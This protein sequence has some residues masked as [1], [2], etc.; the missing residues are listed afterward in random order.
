LPNAKDTERTVTFL[1][2]AG[3]FALA[4]SDEQALA[5][6]IEVGA[7]AV[8]MTE[9][10][11]SAAG[12]Q[13][14]DR[15]LRR[16]PLAESVPLIVLSREA[17]DTRSGFLSE[18]S[19]NV[20][21]VERP[22]RARTLVSVVQATLRAR[23]DQYA[24]RDALVEREHQAAAIRDRDE[25]LQFA[26]EA[27]KLGWW[28]VEF[29]SGNMVCSNICRAHFGRRP[30]E[31]FTYASLHASIHRT[32]AERIQMAISRC[33]YEYADYDVEYRVLWPDGQIHW[34]MVRGKATYREDGTAQ[35]MV[36]VS[37]DITDRKEAEAALGAQAEQLRYS[38][39]R[40]DEFLATLA[41]ELR[42]PLAPI[43]TGLGILKRAPSGES[44]D[45]A[46]DMMD[47][48]LGHM[49][50]LIDDLMDLSRITRGKV[51]LKKERVTLRSVVD[52]TVE[53]TRPLID[54][55]AHK[56]S[57]NLPPEPVYFDVDPTRAGQIIGNL[58]NNAAKYTPDGGHIDIT[59]R[60][61]GPCVVIDVKDDGLGI[62]KEQLASVFDM[63]SQVDRTLERSQG[64]LGIGL[65][66]VRKLL[67]MHEG[68]IS[69]TSGGSGCGSTFTVRFPV[70][71]ELKNA[72]PS[73]A[74][75]SKEHEAMKRILVVDDN[76]DA[77]ECLSMLL[78][79]S[80]HS[81]RMAHSGPDAL[82]AA[83]E[84]QPDIAFLDIGLPGMDGYEVARR[85][86]QDPD[87]H[88]ITLV[89]LTGWGSDE[90]R[91]RSS[92]A[93]FDHH[94]TKPVETDTVESL[95]SAVT[96]SS[97]PFRSMSSQSGFTS[98]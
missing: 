42:N 92:E 44:A 10:S 95:L 86:R 40:K 53:A 13:A 64:G 33:L 68:S 11:I 84:F 57:V 71:V 52:S 69:V 49:V 47:R 39:R 9:E 70:A 48:Q 3:I 63:F 58:V 6:E 22:V 8:L 46:R 17:N 88:G 67:A 87:L 51:E 5:A 18:P 25:R 21:L 27:G 73:H 45:R 12:R 15:A 38:D 93:G 55:A 85:I 83:I 37:L 98:Q 35:Q 20:T 79:I 76:H 26:L 80:G 91:R 54:S 16:E 23:K 59:A 61:E 66:L 77:A 28:E 43:R 1:T 29:P 24:V 36:G 89:A 96:P 34:L 31:V 62:P 50:R 19:R 74:R 72:S 81:T 65:A 82:S 75:Q 30:N 56:L 2:R 14:F 41:H 60:V 94:L 78:E 7:G 90:D 97:S 32:D 4:C